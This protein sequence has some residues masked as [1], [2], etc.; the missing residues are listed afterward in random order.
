MFR[1]ILT[2]LFALAAFTPKAQLTTKEY[3]EDFEYFWRS[4]KEDYCYWDKKAID[5]DKAREIYAPAID[6]IKTRYAFVMLLERMLHEL[7]DHHASLNTNTQQSSKLVP[8]GTDIWA[9]Y[10]NGM[11][12]IVEVK[13]GSGAAMAGIKAGMRVESI[14]G[15]AVQAAIQPFIPKSAKEITDEMRSYALR[16]ALAGTH[17]H[18]RV[19]ALS[20]GKTIRE[21]HPDDNTGTTSEDLIK[22]RW[23]GK[24]GYLQLN[25]KLGSNDMIAAFDSALNRLQHSD[26]LIIDLRNTPSGGVTTVARGIISRFILKEGFYQKHELTAEET[27]YG[28]K[29]SWMEIVSPRGVTYVKPVV[30]LV[31]HWTGSVSEGITIGFDGVKRATIIGTEMAQLNGAVYSYQ[32][33]NSRIGFS[34]PVEKLFHING[35]PREKFKPSLLVNVKEE[36]NNE[37]LVLA[38][39]LNFLKKQLKK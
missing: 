37:D 38:T 24:I 29:R 18:K 21:Y 17:D 36:I 35:T 27:Q 4:I 28:V 11:P 20:S 5:W 6:T 2:V 9:A 22:A 39:A 14:N 26:A 30:I 16:V 23:F 1:Y 34:F 10:I 3:R 15:I 32:M 33:P 31:D 19:L 12:V 7:Y 25:D 13:K 8:S